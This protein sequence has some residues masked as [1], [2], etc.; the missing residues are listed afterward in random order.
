[1]I[2]VGTRYEELTDNMNNTDDDNKSVI[3]ETLHRIP[4]K[5]S[6][7]KDI[8]DVLRKDIQ[9]KQIVLYRKQLIKEGLI[10]EENPDDPDSRVE[11]TT[12]GYNAIEFYGNYIAYKKE[13]E[14]LYKSR[15]NL[16]Y[17]REKNVRLNNINVIIG[18]ISFIAG[19]LLSD[20][21]KSI[22][23]RLIQGD[24]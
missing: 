9:L 4:D 17:L 6:I 13:Q 14:K 1:M 12:E 7:K 5:L 11:I 22:L 24:G 2:P 16:E 3:L 20:P 8:F 18:I 21:I 10:T 15:K 19:I 23:K